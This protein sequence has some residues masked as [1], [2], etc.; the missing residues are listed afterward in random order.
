MYTVIMWSE[1]NGDRY[2]NESTYRAKTY[3]E[4]VRVVNLHADVTRSTIVQRTYLAQV[5]DHLGTVVHDRTF[6]TDGSVTMLITWRT[7]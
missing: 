4:A 6:H 7:N 5:E 1:S 3:R 2:A